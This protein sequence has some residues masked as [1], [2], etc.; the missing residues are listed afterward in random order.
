MTSKLTVSD[1]LAVVDLMEKV[2]ADRSLLVGLS[3]DERTR[4]MHAARMIFSPDVQER[5][6][7]TR[8]EGRRR[9]TDTR[10]RIQDHLNQT[11]IRTLRRKPVYMSPN[12]MPP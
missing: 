1:I 12:I 10:Q 11:G 6:R 4:L 3:A 2:A 8:A 7:L 5:R 9:K